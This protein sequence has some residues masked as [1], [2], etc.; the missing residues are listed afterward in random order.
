MEEEIDKWV[1]H[2]FW[3]NNQCIDHYDTD[4]SLANVTDGESRS[5]AKPDAIEPYCSQQHLPHSTMDSSAFITDGQSPQYSSIQT[6]KVEV[7][8]PVSSMYMIQNEPTIFVP[9]PTIPMQ[10]RTSDSASKD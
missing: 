3:Y 9:S 8:S 4:I 10:N 7:E 2:D 6:L 5:M 1:N